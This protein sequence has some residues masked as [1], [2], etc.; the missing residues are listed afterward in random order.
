MHKIKIIATYKTPF[1]HCFLGLLLFLLPI[2]GHSL[3][4]DWP[5]Y[6]LERQKLAQTHVMEQ[7]ENFPEKPS[8]YAQL[9]RFELNRGPLDLA[10]FD[11]VLSK[12]NQRLDT[13]DF[14]VSVLVRMLYQYWDSPLWEG[15]LRDRVVETLLGFKYWIDEP[16][17]D[18][19]V[20]WSEN[21][22]ILFHSSAYL[23]GQ[24]FPNQVFSNSGL[25]GEAL[26]AKHEPMLKRWIKLRATLGFSE[27]HSN[28]YYE[29]D[30]GPLLN[31]VDFAEDRQLIHN[32][33]G[34]VNLLF[35]D[36]ALYSHDG[37]FG[38]SHGRTFERNVVTPAREGTHATAHLL[39]NQGS[40]SRTGGV[41]FSPLA[42]T[43]KFQ[44][45][46]AVIL[47]GRKD[48]H[49]EAQLPSVWNDNARMGFDV[50]NAAD[51]GITLDSHNLDDAVIWWGN[52]GYMLPET[53][54]GT[55]YAAEQYQLFSE[56]RFFRP[57]SGLRLFWDVGL[58][59]KLSKSPL[60]K[61]ISEAGALNT[62]HTRAHHKP[63]AMLSVAL[64][65]SKGNPSVQNHAWSAVLEGGIQIF[66]SHPLRDVGD[67][68]Y[69]DY[70]TGSASMPRIAQH[71]D[72][73]IILHN[74]NI[75]LT[76][77]VSPEAKTTHTHFPL[78]LFDETAQVGRWHF[79]RK[80]DGYVA[81]YSHNKSAIADSGRY[82]DSELIAKGTKNLWIC[83]IGSQFEDGS[84]DDFVTRISKQKVS[85]S[86]FYGMKTRY[87]S[88]QG[89]MEFSWK[90][91]FIVDKVIQPLNSNAR[92]DNPF[93]YVPWGETRFTINAGQL[94][95]EINFDL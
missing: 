5:G 48:W 85:F 37:A 4:E 36:I 63:S 93:L 72:I 92:Y 76:S 46:P 67:G 94:G 54:A 65:K 86:K 38:G 52:G 23:I 34:L 7:L 33:Q 61:S 95:S 3:P 24:R 39:F 59:P 81:I 83:E 77:F 13:S 84:F 68:D 6:Y 20:Y 35:L 30:I 91:D 42:V 50:T 74:P 44:P 90:K 9:I 21:H 79:G 88:D 11:R 66:S 8:I 28:N 64:D 57:F 2:S 22:Q 89:I 82:A 49:E 25:T 17:L 47:I 53:L 80:N 45:D 56:N 15:G 16:G 69:L 62:T 29:E 27:W 51:Y 58:I 55:F 70:Y 10:E 71:E 60:F 78:H 43:K 1:S 14:Q 32:A 31:L 18:S 75:L 12:L 26:K 73:A 87:E 40:F 41:S 19:M